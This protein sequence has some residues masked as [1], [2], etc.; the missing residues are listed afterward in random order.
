[1]FLDGLSEVG[2]L[3]LRGCLASMAMRLGLLS[4]LCLNIR[5][6]EILT[7]VRGAVSAINGNEL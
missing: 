4:V 7:L 5:G 1:M 3:I 6:L 2:M